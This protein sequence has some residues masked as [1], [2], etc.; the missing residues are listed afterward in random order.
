MEFRLKDA[1]VCRGFLWIFIENRSR[2]SINSN[3]TV[4]F[5]CASLHFSSENSS[6]STEMSEFDWMKLQHG[7]MQI[8]RPESQFIF[9]KN[10]TKNANHTTDKTT[11]KKNWNFRSTTAKKKQTNWL[12]VFWIENDKYFV[13]T[14]KLHGDYDNASAYEM[15]ADRIANVVQTTVDMA[16]VDMA[17]MVVSTVSARGLYCAAFCIHCYLVWVAAILW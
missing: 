1:W 15:R 11:T 16:D 5:V 4:I 13:E 17:T 8:R 6:K 10:Q 3:F 7:R 2:V 12:F 9:Q 14:R